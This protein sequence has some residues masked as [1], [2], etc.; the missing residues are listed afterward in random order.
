MQQ[1]AR[2]SRTYSIT[3]SARASK[4]G[5]TVSPSVLAVLR[6]IDQFVLSR[7]LHWQASGLFASENA[8]DVPS[9]QA[10]LLVFIRSVGSQAAAG[11]IIA[12]GINCRDFVTCGQVG[13]ELRT[14]RAE[15]ARGHNKPAIRLFRELRD[16]TFNL[17]RVS[18]PYDAQLY[19]DRCHSLYRR[20]LTDPG[21]CRR[22]SQDR[23]PCYARCK[24]LE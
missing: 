19:S 23:D 7:G 21:G 4:V 10:V 22:S 20:E 14:V 5:G 9:G 17:C 12:V 6:L 24:L 18:R 1:G 16:T 2:T 11:D 3:S 8:I 13:N 15:A